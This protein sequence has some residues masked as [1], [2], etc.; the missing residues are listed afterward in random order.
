MSFLGSLLYGY[1]Y[2]QSLGATLAQRSY[3]NFTGAGVTVTDNPATGATDVAITGGGGSVPTGT[4]I[5]HIT[6]GAQDAAAVH[7]TAGQIIVSTGTD[8]PF[9]TAS[10][11]ATIASGGALTVAKINGSTVPAGGALTT[12]H[13]L[14]VTGAAALGYAYL[15]DANVDAAAAIA[16]TKISTDFGAQAILTTGYY[17]YG[18]APRASG[19][20]FRHANGLIGIRQRNAANTQDT[21]AVTMNGSGD[22]YLGTDTGFTAA[23]QANSIKLYATVAGSVAIGLSGSTSIFITTDIA[24]AL[25]IHGYSTAWG[26]V[27]GLFT[28]AMAGSTYALGSSEYVYKHIKVTGTGTNVVQLPPAT[29]AQGYSKYIWNAGSGTLGVQDTNT[30]AAAALLAAGTGAWFLF[31]ASS[32]KQLTAAFTVA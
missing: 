18:A 13:M 23:L 29:D 20:S 30:V 32:V 17:G 9:V 3:L 25:P 27:D 28:K 5:P 8:A 15:V 12:G 26:S 19:G 24:C 6:A 2:I 21:Y 22:L 10:G 16:G 31:S 11:D 7:G 14:G 4:G 1:R